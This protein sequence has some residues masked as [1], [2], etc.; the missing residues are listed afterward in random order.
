MREESIADS[1]RNCL[2]DFEVIRKADLLEASTADRNAALE[3]REE[4]TRFKIWSGNMGA[5]SEGRRSLQYRL[6]DASHLQKQV[7]SL[8]D[9]LSELLGDAFLIVSGER[10]P[11]DRVEDDEEFPQDTESESD[12][13]FGDMPGTEVAQ[14]AQN[15]SD[16][17]NCL[18]RLSVAIRNPAPHDRF[19]SFSSSEASHYEP[20]DIQHVKNKFGEIE[21]FLADRLGKAISRRRE[22]F[23]YRESHHLKLKQ[24]LDSVEEDG[25]E[26]TVA[27]SLPLHAKAAGFNLDAM[28]EDGASNS[29]LTQTSF[30]SS[31]ADS[32]KLSVPPLPKEAEDGPFECPF[33]YMMITASSI[34]SWKRHVLADLRPYVCLWEDCTA[35]GM[36]FTRR[37]EWM[38]HEMQNHRKAYNCPCSCGMTFRVR[39]QCKDHI[40]K[41]HP[42]TFPTSQLDTMIDL[43]A[44]PMNEKEGSICP[45]CQE[46][47]SSM[48]DY[49]RHVG[50]HQEQLALF[51]LPSLPT[52]D[53]AQIEENTSGPHTY[54]LF[55]DLNVPYG[56]TKEES[57]PEP[58][59]ATKPISGL[60]KE[61]DDL[62][63]EYLNKW[64]PLCS[65]FLRS[66][67]SKTKKGGKKDSRKLSEDILNHVL[68]KLDAIDTA[69]IPEVRARR[70][71]IAREVRKT[72][73]DLGTVWDS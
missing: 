12:S 29:G 65:D 46:N 11:W 4:E 40:N 51:A 27:S 53:D 66:P 42:K 45:L 1:V 31:R 30:A 3:I 24:G 28:D 6:R 72:L 34:D 60:M 35:P 2:N 61:L 17:V 59:V 22:Y 68:L 5:H 70:K 50:R 58:L 44:R 21:P 63:E 26:S 9:E 7:M 64:V 43:N 32:D 18:L 19:M 48:K 49:Q 38:L 13:E 73:T 57:H 55:E 62:Y 69:G 15:V 54:A 8:L 47:L 37:Y 10:I 56:Q 52:D 41:T 16:V 25:A 23:K 67:P 71:E 36:E 33:C 20:F 14:I 39:S